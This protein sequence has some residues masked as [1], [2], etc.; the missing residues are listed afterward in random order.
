MKYSANE[1][2]SKILT[3]WNYEEL[4]GNYIDFKGLILPSSYLEQN[5]D[6]VIQ[7]LIQDMS[8][9]NAICHGAFLNMVYQTQGTDKLTQLVLNDLNFLKI[10]AKI[11]KQGILYHRTNLLNLISL[12]ILKCKPGGKLVSGSSDTSGPI[13]FFKA[14]S[15]INNQLN[16][17]EGNKLEHLLITYML[18]DHP[19]SYSPT[20]TTNFYLRWLKR[21]WFIY[22]Q[23][24]PA[25]PVNQNDKLISAVSSLEEKLQLNLK[26]YFC[27]L[28]KLFSW[29]LYM[30]T[31]PENINKI[32][33]NIDN[34]NTFYIDKSRFPPESNLIKLI[35]LVSL[36]STEMKKFILDSADKDEEKNRNFSFFYK[37]LTKF[38]QRPFFKVSEG[39]F[40][41]IDF[42]FMIEGIC[43]GLLWQLNEM[44]VANFN[45]LKAQYGRLVES[46]FY[47]I[48]T[49]IFNLE[50]NLF[51]STPDA[52]VK[53][54]DYIIIFEFTTEY[55]R[56]QS[57]YN[58]NLSDFKNDLNKI[59]FN[60]KESQIGGKK[61]K[62]KF[63]KLNNYA[64]DCSC[65]GQYEVIPILITE[66]LLGDYE[67]LNTFDN[68][69]F[70]NICSNNL[71][72]L[73]KRPPYIL[74]LDDIEI[75]W[76]RSGEDKTTNIELF[77]NC[78]NSWDAEAK[79]KF[80][81]NFSFFL[82]NRF[83][84]NKILNSSYVEF[85]EFKNLLK[86]LCD[87]DI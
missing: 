20:T 28:V 2:K 5:I 64:K 18:R 9:N 71:E 70:E 63:I 52:I 35:D 65:N 26:T 87:K 31:Q 75:F 56:M 12:L 61:D 25:L 57:L 85:F 39:L 13:N 43:S 40:L 84:E 55:Y 77:I 19:Y 8:I 73:K 41:I 47:K 15:I 46:Y 38:F 69:L 81:F 54:K 72:Y 6:I 83:K 3:Y 67:L 50:S 44:E 30:P 37:Y 7:D 23:L 36:D 4:F 66:K 51:D 86:E 48:M 45:D 21:Y 33:F 53:Y 60:K 78:I 14:L 59:F 58:S 29:F 32:G 27:I 82:N 74:S 79:G 17:I 24:L 34:V 80:H 1:K 16:S 49:E 11:D 22:N 10:K 68:Y 62:G 76:S 42:K